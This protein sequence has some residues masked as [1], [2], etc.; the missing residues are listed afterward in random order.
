MKNLE[1]F[2]FNR[3]PCLNHVNDWT[4]NAIIVIENQIMAI[5]SYRFKIHVN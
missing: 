4:C 3:K 1:F 2:L 5:L